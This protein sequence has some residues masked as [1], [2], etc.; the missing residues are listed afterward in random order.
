M[1]M[2]IDVDADVA[3]VDVDVNVLMLGLTS[4]LTVL[5]AMSM[6]RLEP[7]DQIRPKSTSY[8]CM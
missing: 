2:L 7:V 1:L 4:M 8:M 3:A 6:L 5:F